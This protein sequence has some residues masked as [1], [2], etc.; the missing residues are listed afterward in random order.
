MIAW[1]LTD[2]L[3][4]LVQGEIQ[5]TKYASFAGLGEDRVNGE[6]FLFEVDQ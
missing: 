4:P 2:L 5:V 1:P 3:V 6:L